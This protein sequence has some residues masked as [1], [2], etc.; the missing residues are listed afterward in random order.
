SAQSITLV[1]PGNV[2]EPGT[3]Y[4][5]H[6]GEHTVPAPAGQNVLFDY[7]ASTPTTSL[8]YHWQ[9]PADL[10]NAAQFPDAEFALTNGGPDTVFYKAT[11]SGLERIGDTE[12]ITA[13]GT[14]YHLVTAYSNS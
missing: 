3:S 4:L 14:E 12:T 9:L 10:P 13:L 6:R 1:A 8:N 7:S 5:V 2:P 11:A